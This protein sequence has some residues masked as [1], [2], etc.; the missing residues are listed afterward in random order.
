[1]CGLLY[2]VNRREFRCGASVVVM[3]VTS[4][5]F[6]NLSTFGAYQK[7]WNIEGGESGGLV[8]WITVPEQPGRGWALPLRAGAVRQVTV[9]SL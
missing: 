5:Y 8:D 1:M 7:C 6:D 3:W 9:C 4:E 2:L